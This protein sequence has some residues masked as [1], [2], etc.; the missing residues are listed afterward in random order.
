[1]GVEI[2]RK[3]L[4]IG[5]EW[6]ALAQP[7]LMRQAYLSS[8][9]DRVVRVRIEGELAFLTIKSANQ[10]ISRS[11][12]EY[13][14]PL[15]DAQEMLE[16]VCEQPLIEKF[17]YRIPCGDHLWEFDE[18]LGQNAGL[19]VAEIELQAEHEAFLRP[20][21]LGEEVS[22]DHRYANARLFKHPYSR[23]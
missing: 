23:W 6:K 17:R 13:P 21:W 7:I 8:S 1:M 4:V 18:F 11:E 5:E 9:P 12:W 2:E 16:R 22:H 20:P 10:G 19:C 3:F 15:S 14:I